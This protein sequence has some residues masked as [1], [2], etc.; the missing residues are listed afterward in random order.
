MMKVTLWGVALVLAGLLAGPAGAAESLQ[1]IQTYAQSKRP[2]CLDA[3]AQEANIYQG[4]PHQQRVFNPTILG[5]VAEVFRT[6][7]AEKTRLTGG[8]G[9]PAMK[10]FYVAALWAAGLPDEARSYARANGLAAAADGLQA[11]PPRTLQQITPLDNAA[12]NDVLIGAFLAS[13]NP[14]HL[15][16]VLGNYNSAG[17]GMAEDALRIAM[18]LGKFGNAFG[19]PGRERRMGLAAC[20]KYECK[21]NPRDFLRVMTLASASWAVGSLAGQNAVAKQTFDAFFAGDARLGRLLAVER[22]AFA[23]YLTTYV[24]WHAL[25]STPNKNGAGADTLKLNESLSTYETLSP[26]GEGLK[27]P[28]GK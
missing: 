22:N 27:A 16:K 10:G 11:H 18:M 12:D 24:A 23:N 26:A 8:S 7:P 5:F 3:V 28:A 4:L 13:G 20:Q 14:D 15:R 19:P 6:A 17:D 21:E 1:C 9:S 25:A 2:A